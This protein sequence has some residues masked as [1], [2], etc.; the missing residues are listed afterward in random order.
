MTEKGRRLAA[1]R[2]SQGDS[3]QSRWWG[4]TE[5]PQRGVGIGS[6]HAGNIEG[7]GKASDPAGL[8]RGPT[9]EVRFGSR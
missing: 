5:G 8:R 6:G 3:V 1:E 9:H 7:A 2:S 4:R